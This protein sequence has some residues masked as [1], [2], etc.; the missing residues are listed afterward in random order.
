[1]ALEMKELSSQGFDCWLSRVESIEKTCNISCNDLG[2]S[3]LN[4]KRITNIIRSKFDLHWLKKIREIKR[5]KSD[6]FTLNHNKDMEK[7]I[8]EGPSEGRT[9][10]FI[11]DD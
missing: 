7:F 2:L 5:D 11:V 6:N 9:G 3:S 1:M 8:G 10:G 4:T